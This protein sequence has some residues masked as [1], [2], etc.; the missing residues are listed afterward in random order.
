MRQARSQETLERLL[1]SAESLLAKKG[2]EGITVAEIARRAGASVGALY[3]RFR[4]KD[5]VLQ[6]L[7]DRFVAEVRATTSETLDV[8]R[9]QGAST[10]EIVTEFVSFLVEIHRTRVGLLRELVAR[11]HSAAPVIERK[12]GLI[13]HIG[14]RLSALL[15]VRSDEIAHPDPAY[16]V[17][18]GVRLVLGCLEQAILSND[19]DTYY[20]LPASD[21]RLAAELTRTYLSYLGVKRGS[22]VAARPIS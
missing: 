13:Q 3:S 9:W 4:G 10:E 16:A 7:L 19:S 17:S 21:E 5:A 20:G 15:L 1:D 14:D 6:C 12:E 11:A 18:F 8:E 22:D 2:F